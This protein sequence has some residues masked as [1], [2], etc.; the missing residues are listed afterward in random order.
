MYHHYT[1]RE[2]MAIA[3][4]LFGPRAIYISANY[5]KDMEYSLERINDLIT[6]RIAELKEKDEYEELDSL[7]RVVEPAKRYVNRRPLD[8]YHAE[9]TD[10][11]PSPIGDIGF[12]IRDIRYEPYSEVTRGPNRA[13]HR[14]KNDI[15]TSDLIGWL[16]ENQGRYGG[17]GFDHH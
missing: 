5:I 15:T 12:D 9:I 14:G 3:K 7:T 11:P 8:R 13:E 2:Q 4:S 10:E 16:R 6:D 1:A 17:Y